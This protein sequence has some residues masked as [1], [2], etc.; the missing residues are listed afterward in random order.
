MTLI[1]WQGELCRE[2]EI[3]GRCKGFPES[4]EL[5]HEIIKRQTKIKQTKQQHKVKS[6]GKKKQMFSHNMKAAPAEVKMSWVLLG[7]EHDP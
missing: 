5:Y 2:A 6:W 1:I 3:W 4:M 7:I